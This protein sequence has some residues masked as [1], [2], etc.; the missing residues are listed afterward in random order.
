MSDASV[1]IPID[2]QLYGTPVIEA[3]HIVLHHSII[4]DLRERI[5]SI[6]ERKKTA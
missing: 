5:K 4:Y 3:M 6:N 2:L 1:I